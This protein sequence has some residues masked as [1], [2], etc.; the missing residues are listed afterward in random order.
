MFLLSLRCPY[1][2]R[3]TNSPDFSGGNAAI[4]PALRDGHVR[5]PRAPSSQDSVRFRGHRPGLFSIGPSGTGVSEGHRQPL[6]LRRAGKRAALVDERP[7][8]LRRDGMRT[9]L[10][11]KIPSCNGPEPPARCVHSSR[12]RSCPDSIGFTRQRFPY[13]SIEID[14]SRLR[15]MR[16]RKEAE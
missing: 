10:V 12:P 7:L 8:R 15:Q 5:F 11:N 4:R 6:R 13:F 14:G 9:S 2:A 1:M 3:L 16:L